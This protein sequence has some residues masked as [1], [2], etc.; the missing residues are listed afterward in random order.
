MGTKERGRSKNCHWQSPQSRSAHC[1]DSRRS[2]VATNPISPTSWPTPARLNWRKNGSARTPTDPLAAQAR[3]SGRLV[4][5]RELCIE[6]RCLRGVARA[7]GVKAVVPPYSPMTIAILA[8]PENPA[9]KKEAQAPSV[10]S[11]PKSSNIQHVRRAELRHVLPSSRARAVCASNEAHRIDERTQ[12]LR[13]R[14]AQELFDLGACCGV[15]RLVARRLG[16]W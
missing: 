5:R 14:H 8:P 9:T 10:P 13:R 11:R 4:H 1:G 12:P 3:P 6:R 16:C 7:L 2:R 15:N